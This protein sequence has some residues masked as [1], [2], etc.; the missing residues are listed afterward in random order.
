MMIPGRLGLIQ[1][2]F[3]APTPHAGRKLDFDDIADPSPEYRR[4][5]GG[6]YRDFACGGVRAARK[7]ERNRQRLAVCR[8]AENHAAVHGH[9]VWRNLVWR[10]LV[11][12]PQLVGQGPPA[13]VSSLVTSVLVENTNKTLNVMA[14][15]C[16]FGGDHLGFPRVICRDHRRRC[17]APTVWIVSTKEDER[18]ARQRRGPLRSAW[19][20]VP[21]RCGEENDFRS[22]TLPLSQSISRR[23]RAAPC[24]GAAAGRA[25]STAG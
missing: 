16:G 15:K 22:M 19:P 14:R 2:G 11:R 9:E 1:H 8:L 6:E 3:D 20:G 23:P 4:T 17:T 24:H 13:A 21:A 7:H 10:E 25:S 12:E 5:E 18:D